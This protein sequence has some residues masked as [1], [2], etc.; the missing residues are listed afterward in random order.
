MKRS[1]L[2]LTGPCALVVFATCGCSDSH[3]PAPG[4]GEPGSAAAPV[5]EPSDETNIVE[6]LILPTGMTALGGKNV[7]PSPAMPSDTWREDVT[8]RIVTGE[9]AIRA[10]AS[11]LSAYNRAHRMNV[12]WEAGGVRISASEQEPLVMRTTN[13]ARGDDRIAAAGAAFAAGACQQ[14][15]ARDEMDHCLQRAESKQSRWLEWWENRQNG[16]EQGFELAEAPLGQADGAPL[17]IELAVD[18][19]RVEVDADGR[20]ATLITSLCGALGARRE[21]A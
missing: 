16:L 18:G 3:G 21:G 6:G 11:G 7:P 4:T 17:R 20:G 2:S 12:R 19:A 13:F 10:G 1:V 5:D 9:Y 8:T 15:G 14:D